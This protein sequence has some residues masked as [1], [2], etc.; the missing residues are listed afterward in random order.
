MV[1][2]PPQ[3]KIA[4]EAVIER[5][6]FPKAS[7]TSDEKGAKEVSKSLGGKFEGW[8]FPTKFFWRCLSCGRIFFADLVSTNAGDILMPEFVL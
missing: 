5:W 1:F 7:V 4:P 8:D 2:L 6:V 3:I